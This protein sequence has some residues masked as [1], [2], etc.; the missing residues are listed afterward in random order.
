MSAT[1]L[2]VSVAPTRFDQVP[3]VQEHPGHARTHR[4]AP[5]QSDIDVFHI[6]I[7]KFSTITTIY[8]RDRYESQS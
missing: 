7:L 6:P 5:E 1:R 4:A 3:A 8:Y 2:R